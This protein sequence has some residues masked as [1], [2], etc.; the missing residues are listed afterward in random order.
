MRSFSQKAV[1]PRGNSCVSV[2][3]SRVSRHVECPSVLPHTANPSLPTPVPAIILKE[4]SLSFP[5]GDPVLIP[6]THSGIG[7]HG[8]AGAPF[9]Y[10]ESRG[11]GCGSSCLAG[12]R[13]A[14]PLPG[15]QFL[16]PGDGN[17][18]TGM[19]L[20]CRAFL[21]DPPES[22]IAPYSGQ[23]QWQEAGHAVIRLHA[24]MAA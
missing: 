11:I 1:R 3:P 8:K 15:S 13:P 2:M 22:G 9:F 5:L 16:I 23:Y 18:G 20:S 4:L 21:Q 19:M 12:Q 14:L 24:V 7:R 17:P 6:G 10:S